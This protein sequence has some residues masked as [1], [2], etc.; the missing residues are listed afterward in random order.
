MQHYV[1]ASFIARDA[2]FD[3][4]I[5]V[6]R[7]AHSR[8]PSIDGG[9]D[10]EVSESPV[11]LTAGSTQPGTG[12]TDSSKPAIKRGPTKCTCGEKGEHYAE[13]AMEAVFPSSPESIYNLM[14]PSQFMRSFMSDNQ[15]LTG[16]F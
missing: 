3:V 14:F 1:F 16:K 7:Q 4:F 10:Q 11:Q 5:N 15:K 13:K 2:T 12:K 9:D 6:W 8:T